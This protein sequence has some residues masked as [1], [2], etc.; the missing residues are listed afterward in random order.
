MF[1]NVVLRRILSQGEC[2]VVTWS[3]TSDVE[4]WKGRGDVLPDDYLKDEARIIC[5]I[6]PSTT[7][8]PDTED[9]IHCIECTNSSHRIIQNDGIWELYTPPETRHVLPY[10]NTQ[11][12]DQ[13]ECAIYSSMCRVKS[14]SNPINISNIMKRLVSVQETPGL[15]VGID[16]KFVPWE[17]NNTLWWPR[18]VVDCDCLMEAIKVGEEGDRIL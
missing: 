9:V 12:R 7:S 10:I 8:M 15:R 17:Q 6:R 11:E 1:M 5:Y 2:V 14:L 18:V 3:A 13:W 4:I 16:A